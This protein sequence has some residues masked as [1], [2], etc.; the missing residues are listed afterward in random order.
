MTNVAFGSTCEGRDDRSVSS[1]LTVSNGSGM[2]GLQHL[3]SPK[4][5][6]RGADW[7]VCTD[8]APSIASLFRRAHIAPPS[9]ARQT[10]P[11][12]PDLTRQSQ[13]A[14]AVQ[15]VVPRRFEFRQKCHQINGLPK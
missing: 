3:E 14:A 4:I 13:T 10:K 6:H 15:G 2:T 8:A 1:G 5:H 12:D 9:R 7:L 11:P